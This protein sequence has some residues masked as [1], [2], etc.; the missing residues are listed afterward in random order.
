MDSSVFVRNP[1][2]QRAAVDQQESQFHAPTM[3]VRD[4]DCS[5]AGDAPLH[6]EVRRD[7]F[8]FIGEALIHGEVIVHASETPTLLKQVAVA[9]GL[10]DQTLHLVRVPDCGT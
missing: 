4:V 5:V 7:R 3:K 6:S 9:Y 10:L 8:I 1:E 2:V